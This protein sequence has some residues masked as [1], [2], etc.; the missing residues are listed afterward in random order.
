M[1]WRRMLAVAAV[2]GLVAAC[3]GSEIEDTGPQGRVPQF[4]VECALSHTAFVD[5]IVF[6]GQ[7]NRSH[8]HDF[9]GN[10]STD[11]HSTYQS[12]VGAQTTCN[13]PQ[14]TA[15]YW[16]PALLDYGNVVEPVKAVAYYRPGP[17]VDPASIQAYPPDLRVISSRAAWS[18]GTGAKRSKRPPDCPTT[19]DLRMLV[20]F[21]DCWN[22]TA[23]DSDDHRSHLAYSKAGACPADHPVPVPQLTLSVVYPA[24]AGEHDY[25]LASGDLTTAHADFFNSWDQQRL[26]TEVRLCLH[27]GV[28]CSVASGRT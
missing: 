22:G 10:H 16:S 27:R 26:E 19:E 3:A 9:F 4:V 8:L 18:C 24:T 23:T 13:N 21:P 28:V 6:P 20:T 5:P 2:A 14:D 17:G 1:I 12:L 11:E 15:S 7:L 25:S